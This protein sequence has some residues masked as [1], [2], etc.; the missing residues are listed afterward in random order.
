M[1]TD[2]DIA[3]DLRSAIA[4]SQRLTTDVATMPKENQWAYLWRMLGMLEQAAKNAAVA[5]EQRT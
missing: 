3:N 1:P 2:A 4:D 5:L